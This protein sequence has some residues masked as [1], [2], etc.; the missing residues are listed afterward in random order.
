M[1]FHAIKRQGE[2]FDL[3]ELFGERCLFI[4]DAEGRLVFETSNNAVIARLLEIPEGFAP[5]D[6]PSAPKYVLESDGERVDL[7]AMDDIA[8][9]EFAKRYDV[10]IPPAAKGDT[11]R[12][13]IVE[14]LTGG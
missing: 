2:T 14:A 9:R 10:K 12:K 8:L 13:K 1:R 3:G 6:A 5:L 4:P 11:I 7:G